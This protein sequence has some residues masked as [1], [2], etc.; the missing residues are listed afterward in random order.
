MIKYK[1]YL[2][3]QPVTKE[4]ATIFQQHFPLVVPHLQAEDG[5]AFLTMQNQHKFNELMS[6]V[7]RECFTKLEPK[8][9]IWFWKPD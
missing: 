8:K 5:I 7:P 9:E 2:N 3:K 1:I 4:N 6:H